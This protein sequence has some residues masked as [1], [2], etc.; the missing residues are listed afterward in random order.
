MSQLVKKGKGFFIYQNFREMWSKGGSEMF[1]WLAVL[2]ATCLLNSKE[3]LT[4]SEEMF[5]P[6]ENNPITIFGSPLHFLRKLIQHFRHVI[7]IIH[8]RLNLDDLGIFLLEL[9]FVSKSFEWFLINFGKIAPTLS[10]HPL[11]THHTRTFS[12]RLVH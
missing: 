10:I 5:H 1:L 8:F 7:K 12:R 4:I 3:I 11:K 2:Y 9:I 6:L